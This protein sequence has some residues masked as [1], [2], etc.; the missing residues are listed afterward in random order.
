MPIPAPTSPAL[1]VPRSGIRTLMDLALR[2]PDAL[3]LEIGEPDQT[4]APHVVDA[5]AALWAALSDEP[6]PATSDAA[7]ANCSVAAIT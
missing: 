5:A 4:P 1:R 6:M 3:H 2:D 7:A